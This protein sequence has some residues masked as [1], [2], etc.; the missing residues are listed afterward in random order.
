[1]SF[2]IIE[3]DVIENSFPSLASEVLSIALRRELEHPTGTM[4]NFQKVRRRIEALRVLR[5][6]SGGGRPF[7]E[8]R[9]SF[10][11]RKLG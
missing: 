11:W 6:Y 8:D 7:I 5:P 10:E 4:E 3:S 9:L 2:S 1:L